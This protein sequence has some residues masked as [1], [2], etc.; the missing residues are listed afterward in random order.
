MKLNEIVNII[1]VLETAN[2]GTR[3][4][5]ARVTPCDIV[6]FLNSSHYSESKEKNIKYG[7]LDLF[8]VLRI[9]LKYSRDNLDNIENTTATINGLKSKIQKIRD[10]LN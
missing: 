1:K 3:P 6:E 7:E 4:R 10:A 2:I 9:F 8:H 5:R